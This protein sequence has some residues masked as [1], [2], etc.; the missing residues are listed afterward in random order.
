MRIT[1]LIKNPIEI[2]LSKE[3]VAEGLEFV[4]K[5]REN[6]EKHGVR[7][8]MFDLKNTSEGINII[9]HLGEVAAANLLGLTVN[10]DIY[11]HGDGGMDLELNGTTIQ[12]KTSK[13]PKMIFNHH[14]GFSTDI[15]VLAQYIGEDNRHAEYDPRFL[16]WGWIDKEGFM[17]KYY[18]Y[19]FGYGTRLVVESIQLNPIDKLP[20]T[21]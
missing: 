1:N 17:E 4:R 18:P 9:G 21:K 15:A 3:E 7:D 12:V 19:D 2:V 8:M 6:K 11:V 14:L 20:I 10:R 5:V 13:L 16:I